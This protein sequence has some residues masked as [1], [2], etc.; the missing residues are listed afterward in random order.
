M[1]SGRIS[2]YSISDF[3]SNASC[4]V[5]LVAELNFRDSAIA[6][7]N[8]WSFSCSDYSMSDYWIAA[9][10]SDFSLAASISDFSWAS[11]LGPHY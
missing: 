9:S 1:S 4:Y 8:S 5:V 11:E 3:D 10:I 7:E 2:E 6:F